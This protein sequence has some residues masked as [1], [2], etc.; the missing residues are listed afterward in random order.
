MIETCLKCGHVNNASTGDDSE[1]CPQCGAIYSKVEMAMAQRQAKPEAPGFEARY[2]ALE[3][4]LTKRTGAG[5]GA[6]MLVLMVAIPIAWLFATQD[7]KP[8]PGPDAQRARETMEAIATAQQD[9]LKQAI[10]ERRV[11]IGMTAAQAREAW[12]KPS[13]INRT[14]SA[15]GAREQWVYG[16]GDYVYLRNDVVESVQTSRRQ[17]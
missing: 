11:L 9:R 17:P 2:N 6:W 8:Q 10:L 7:R 1:A 12:G 3:E 16:I 14:E 13:S 15:Y 4:S 5:M